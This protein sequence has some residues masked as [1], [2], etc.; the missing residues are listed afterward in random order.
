MNIDFYWDVQHTWVA[1]KMEDSNDP[2]IVKKNV[3]K[4]VIVKK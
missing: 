3:V 2:P 4:T 1:E